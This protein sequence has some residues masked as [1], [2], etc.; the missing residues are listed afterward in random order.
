MLG[1]NVSSINKLFISSIKTKASKKCAVWDVHIV[2]WYEGNLFLGSNSVL[3]GFIYDDCSNSEDVGIDLPKR[4]SHA[5]HR[6][7]D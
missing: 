1:I 2:F 5:V 7:S 4:H 6:R 3:L